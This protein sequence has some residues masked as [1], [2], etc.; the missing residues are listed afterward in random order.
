MTK[1]WGSD[2]A[3]REERRRG[4]VRGVFL[5]YQESSKSHLSGESSRYWVVTGG[6]KGRKEKSELCQELE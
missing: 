1:Y 2:F 4:G 5:K 3:L 6:V